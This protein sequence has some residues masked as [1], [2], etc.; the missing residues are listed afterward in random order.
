MFQPPAK[1]RRHPAAT[2]I[3]YLAMRRVAS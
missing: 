3:G 1:P 2:R